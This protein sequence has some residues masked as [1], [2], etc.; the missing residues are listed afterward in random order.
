M[1]LI[2]A[3]F[4][5]SN[6]SQL[7]LC[8]FKLDCFTSVVSILLDSLLNAQQSVNSYCMLTARQ[9]GQLNRAATPSSP[10][11]Y[12]SMSRWTRVGMS[13]YMGKQQLAIKSAHSCLIIMMV[14]L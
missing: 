2:K 9:W 10:L 5:S 6:I 12:G 11:W 4:F 3:V 8:I 7:S 1:L 13:S 14:V